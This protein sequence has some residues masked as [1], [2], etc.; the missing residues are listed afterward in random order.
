M[1]YDKNGC[2]IGI[3]YPYDITTG[4][5]TITSRDVIQ[6]NGTIKRYYD[7]KVPTLKLNQVDKLV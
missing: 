4:S 5:H 2:L 3:G 6:K 7:V 1:K